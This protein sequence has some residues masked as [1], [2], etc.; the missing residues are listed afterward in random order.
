MQHHHIPC[1]TPPFCHIGLP[2]T[3]SGQ[4]ELPGTSSG[5]EIGDFTTRLDAGQITGWLSPAVLWAAAAAAAAPQSQ[6]CVS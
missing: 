4:R 1:R 3:F 2:G 5:H 6:T